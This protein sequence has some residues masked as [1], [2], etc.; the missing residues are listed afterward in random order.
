MPAPFGNLSDVVV[1]YR[2]THCHDSTRDEAS[3]KYACD[4][5]K[6]TVPGLTR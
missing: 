4:P 2:V 3:Y 1:R 6:K 5:Y